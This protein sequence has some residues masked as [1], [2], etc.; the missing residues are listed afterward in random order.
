[1]ARN[2]LCNNSINITL[3]QLQF[4][5]YTIFLSVLLVSVFLPL[6]NLFKKNAPKLSIHLFFAN[7]LAKKLPLMGRLSNWLHVVQSL[8]NCKII[9]YASHYD[10]HIDE[11]I[12]VLGAETQL[13]PTP[14]PVAKQWLALLQYSRTLFI[15]FSNMEMDI[16]LDVNF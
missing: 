4:C 13:S 11:G 14:T 10:K 1:M 7:R 8:V 16:V 12:W 15:F 3:L 6:S 2:M 9:R 5:F